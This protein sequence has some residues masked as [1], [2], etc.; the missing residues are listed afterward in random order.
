M[1]SMQTNL[2]TTLGRNCFYQVNPAKKRQDTR[3]LAKDSAGSAAGADVGAA[4]FAVG[5]QE[6]V[7]EE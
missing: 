1:N 3:R 6:T 2:P 7:G 4:V 5:S